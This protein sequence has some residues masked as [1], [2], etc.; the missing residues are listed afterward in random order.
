MR[1]EHESVIEGN[2]A[3]RYLDRNGVDHIAVNKLV[4][5][6]FLFSSKDLEHRTRSVRYMLS[7]TLASYQQGPG[8]IQLHLE[9]I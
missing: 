9:K 5:E 8:H 7:N 6:D 1:S 2:W 3:Q 4:V